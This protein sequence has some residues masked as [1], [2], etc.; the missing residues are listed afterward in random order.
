MPTALLLLSLFRRTVGRRPR[1][2]PEADERLVTLEE[3]VAEF[4]HMLIRKGLMTGHHLAL[5]RR[6]V[7]SRGVVTGLRTTGAA[8]EDFREV[9][10]DVMVSRPSGGQFPV[11]ETALIPASALP[12]V[13]PGS[14]IDAY[15]RIGDESTIAVCVSPS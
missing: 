6:G 11:R 14:I 5:I 15:Y 9:E 2:C 4:D 3:L 8:C 10:L 12:K 1:A 13:A 7:R